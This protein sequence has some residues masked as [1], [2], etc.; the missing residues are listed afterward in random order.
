MTTVFPIDGGC[1][2]GRVRYRVAR[3]PSRTGICHCRSCRLA[4][5][6]ESVGWAVS[7]EDAFAFTRGE[8]RA[9][10]SSAGVERTFCGDC[11]TTLTY[12]REARPFVDVTLATLDDPEVLPPQKETWC[13]ERVSW[14]PLNRDLVHHERGSS[15][16]GS[17]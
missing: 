14:N 6:A 7:D 11:G 1:L 9:F 17:T 4:T 8:P 3:R 2:C 10:Q 16:K 12:R 5:G 15:E 13:Q